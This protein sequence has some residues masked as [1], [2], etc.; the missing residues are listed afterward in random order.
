MRKHTAQDNKQK[1]LQIKHINYR[2]DARY[3]CANVHA[4]TNTLFEIY[5][6]NNIENMAC[7]FVQRSLGGLSLQG[8]DG[9]TGRGQT[10]EQ[11]EMFAG[12]NL[13]HVI[14]I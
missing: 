7:T 9:K 11:P 12:C 2:L 3:I 10:E 8:S 1:T 13:D 6:I 4:L 14:I 5:F